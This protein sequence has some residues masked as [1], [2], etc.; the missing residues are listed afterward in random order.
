MVAVHDQGL[1]SCFPVGGGRFEGR[2]AHTV[3]EGVVEQLR[4]TRMELADVADA[5]EH[6][7]SVLGDAEQQ[8]DQRLREIARWQAQQQAFQDI[9]GHL[10]PD[11]LN[12]SEPAH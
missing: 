5:I 10:P 8:Q 4:L 1:E 3:L 6:L 7:A 11:L 9:L 2:T 12:R